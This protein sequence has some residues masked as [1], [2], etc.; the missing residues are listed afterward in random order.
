MDEIENITKGI[1]KVFL[2]DLYG[3]TKIKLKQIQPEYLKENGTLIE[4]KE[5]LYD[6]LILIDEAINNEVNGINH[7]I[8]NFTLD[9]RKRRQYYIY[10]NLL[11]LKYNFNDT[12]ITAWIT[13]DKRADYKNSLDSAEL[14]GMEEVH[15][16][17]N[18][19]EFTLHVNVAKISLAKIQIYANQ[20]YNVTEQHKAAVNYLT[21]V[22]EVEDYDYTVG[23]PSKLTFDI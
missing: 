23:Y 21:T 17:F 9:F 12:S 3:D 19:I 22:K 6:I 16:V 18:G 8:K 4:N 10:Y 13:P 20:C 14:L 5:K 11:W 1:N 2:S 7:F 15:P